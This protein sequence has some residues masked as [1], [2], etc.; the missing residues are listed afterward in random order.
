MD[1]GQDGGL[2]TRTR[3]QEEGRNG[4]ENKSGN[5]EMAKER[6]IEGEGKKTGPVAVEMSA[7]GAAEMERN[8]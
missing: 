3:L 4:M 7:T 5:G 1:G 6:K 2:E 8:V